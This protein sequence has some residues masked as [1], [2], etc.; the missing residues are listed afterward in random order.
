MPEICDLDLYDL[1]VGKTQT[2]FSHVLKLYH[3]YKI[4]YPCL[5]N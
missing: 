1:V 3:P 4:N 2:F 5:D